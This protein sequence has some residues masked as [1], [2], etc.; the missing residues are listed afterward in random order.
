MG[1]KQSVPA[2]LFLALSSVSTQAAPLGFKPSVEA[3][4]VKEDISRRG[5]MSLALAFQ[6]VFPMNSPFATSQGTAQNFRY[7]APLG[8]GIEV[9]YQLY[10]R[11]ELLASLGYRSYESRAKT[12][13]GA[14]ALTEYQTTALT[15][16][17]ILIAGRYRLGE[18]MGWSP[19]VEAGLGMTFHKLDITSTE[20]SV[21]SNHASFS[22]FEGYGAVGAAFAWLENYSLH[23]SVG[24]AYSALGS[25]TYSSK[26][27]QVA[28]SGVYSKALVRYQF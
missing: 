20:A 19:E 17:P 18:A 15:S 1:M 26:V 22:G 2:A 23:L 8:V 9:G 14:S 24:Y 4:Y 27:S 25:A 7:Q 12:G 10:D 28:L 6:A 11:W 3:P 5:G 21:A 13:V 16:Y